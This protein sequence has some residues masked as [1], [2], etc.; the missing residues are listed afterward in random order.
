LIAKHVGA[1]IYVD[2]WASWY[3]PCRKYFPWIN[4]MQS[5]FQ[6]KGFKVISINVDAEKQLAECF[7]IGNP[8]NFSVVYDP[9]GELA[10]FLKSKACQAV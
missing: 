9:K 4:N 7:L 5:R 1:V 2:F 8:A 3:G 10:R 6:S